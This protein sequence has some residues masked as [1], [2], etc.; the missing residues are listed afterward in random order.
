MNT[1]KQLLFFSN[2]KKIIRRPGRRTDD[3][4]LQSFRFIIKNLVDF[5]WHNQ[6]R[7][8]GGEGKFMAIDDHPGLALEDVVSFF[9]DFV[10]VAGGELAGGNQT[11]AKLCLVVPPASAGPISS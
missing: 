4:K 11:W 8:A 7:L 10:V 3:Q 9:A 2:L 6:Q 1:D 5:P